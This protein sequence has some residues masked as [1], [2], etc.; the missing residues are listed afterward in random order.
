VPTAREK[1][2][3]AIEHLEDGPI[4]T[5]YLDSGS[6]NWL[7]E[8]LEAK[9]RHTMWLEPYQRLVRRTLLSFQDA[10]RALEAD[11]ATEPRKRTI[12]RKQPARGRK[13]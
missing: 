7:V 11:Q 2:L 9:T 6:Y 5:V 12:P 13:R 8:I 10:K 4:Y 3:V 1:R